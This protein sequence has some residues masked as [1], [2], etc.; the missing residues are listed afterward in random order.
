MFVC[1]KKKVTRLIC[2]KTINLLLLDNELS[3]LD[4]TYIDISAKP[5]SPGQLAFKPKKNFFSFKF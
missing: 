5:R 4:E 2:V 3:G 1:I